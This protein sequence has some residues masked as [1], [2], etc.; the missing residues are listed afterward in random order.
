MTCRFKLDEGTGSRRDFV[1][2][3]PNAL[4]A[5]SACKVIDRWFSRHFSIFDEFCIRRWTKE[6]S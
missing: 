5:S 6:V 2:A 3:R 1:V 4:A